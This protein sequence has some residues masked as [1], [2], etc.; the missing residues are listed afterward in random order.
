MKAVFNTYEVQPLND[1]VGDAN[2]LERAVANFSIKYL[3]SNKLMD[4]E[5]CSLTKVLLLLFFFLMYVDF[6]LI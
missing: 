3:T 2:N 4:L 6:L 5:V 1:E